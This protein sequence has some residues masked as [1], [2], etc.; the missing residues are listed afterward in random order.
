MWCLMVVVVCGDVWGN[1][2]S[3]LKMALKPDW[4]S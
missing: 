1:A 2:L 3:G 4:D